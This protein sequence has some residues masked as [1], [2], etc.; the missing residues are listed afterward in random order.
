L[1]IDW[2][3]QDLPFASVLD[4]VPGRFGDHE[5]DLAAAF[6]VKPQGTC[7]GHDQPARLANL[8]LID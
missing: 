7:Q 8:A 1:V 5:P 3:S 6:L 2:L 4:D